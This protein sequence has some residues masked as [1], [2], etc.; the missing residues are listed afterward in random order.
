MDYTAK[1]RFLKRILILL[2]ALFA[3]SI[4]SGCSH[5][6]VNNNAVEGDEYVGDLP[7]GGK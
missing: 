5:K 2:T 4:F 3:I 6:A 1:V 7:S